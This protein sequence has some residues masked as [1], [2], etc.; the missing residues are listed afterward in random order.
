V[1]KTTFSRTASSTI[2][3]A[4]SIDGEPELA[5]RSLSIHLDNSDGQD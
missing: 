4:K 2:V 3:F 5:M 1:A